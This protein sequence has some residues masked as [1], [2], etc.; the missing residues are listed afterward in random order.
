MVMCIMFFVLLSADDAIASPFRKRAIEAMEDMIPAL[1]Q[2][3]V[4]NMLFS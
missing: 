1:M 4:I 2:R 3:L